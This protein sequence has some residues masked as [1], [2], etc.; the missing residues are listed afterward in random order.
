[1]GKVAIENL[2]FLFTEMVIE[3]SSRFHMTLVQ[4]AQFDW[5]LVQYTG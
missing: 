1:M 2:K 3:K 5:L 4:I